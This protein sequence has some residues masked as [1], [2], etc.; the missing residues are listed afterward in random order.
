M[1]DPGLNSVAMSHNW[2][3]HHLPWLAALTAIAAMLR[4]KSF[5]DF[6]PNERAG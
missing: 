4:D 5:V 3:R 6:D 1:S 2:L